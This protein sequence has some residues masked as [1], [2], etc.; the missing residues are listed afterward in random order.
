MP[1]KESKRSASRVL[2][3]ILGSAD[4]L[5]HVLVGRVLVSAASEGFML[6]KAP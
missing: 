1:L 2:W 6:Y 5:V 3:K 4:I